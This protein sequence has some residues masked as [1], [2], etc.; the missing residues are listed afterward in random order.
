MIMRSEFPENKSSAKRKKKLKF[1]TVYSTFSDTEKAE[2]TKFVKNGVNNKRNNYDKILNS[3]KINDNG[4]IEIKGSTSD[5]TRWNRFSELHKLADEFLILKSIEG[6]DLLNKFLLFKEYG[7]RNLFASFEQKYESIK[8]ETSNSPLVNFDANTINQIERIY[9]NHLRAISDSKNLI[10]KIF[11]AGISR[12]GFF[13]IELLENLIEISAIKGSKIL[14]TISM[15]EKIY[16][17]LNIEKILLHFKETSNSPHKIYYTIRF[18]HLVYSCNKDIS[19]NEY[20]TEAKRILYKEL[21]SISDDKREIYFISLINFKI[22][23]LNNFIPGAVEELFSLMNKKL[24]EGLVDDFRNKNLPVNQFRDFILVGLNLKKYK[25]VSNF[26]DNYSIYLPEEIRHDYVCLAK[27]RLSFS[28]KNY[29]SSYDS[30]KKVNKKNHMLFTDVTLLKLKVLFEL[31]K[32]DES[33]DELKNFREYLR[34]DRDYDLMLFKNSREFCRAYSLLLK[35]K[36]NPTVKNLNDLQ[37][38]LSK[39]TMNGKNWV[40]KKMNGIKIN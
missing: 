35:L 22:A 16:D 17:N 18:L 23:Q 10:T 29:G 38:M 13:I 12:N 33:Y 30:L 19:S 25:W 8:N 21:K 2:F 6:N 7:K 3:L 31:N 14:N 40:T 15:D 26:I 24:E 4:D 39:K 28:M 1:I 27:A 5:V 37:Y 9:F 32:S 36:Q 20:Y 11:E 34:K